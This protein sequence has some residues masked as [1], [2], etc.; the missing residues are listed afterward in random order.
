MSGSA[1][2]L[3]SADSRANAAEKDHFGGMARRAHRRLDEWTDLLS[4]NPDRR[5]QTHDYADS[6]MSRVS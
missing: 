2:T 6:A 4:G 1:S 5:L 3:V